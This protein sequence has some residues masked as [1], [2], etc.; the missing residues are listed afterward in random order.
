MSTEVLR[1]EGHEVMNSFTLDANGSGILEEITMEETVAGSRTL[2]AA[3][4]KGDD[5]DFSY[6]YTISVETSDPSGVKESHSDS[7]KVLINVAVFFLLSPKLPGNQ[8]PVCK[9]QKSSFTPSNILDFF[10]FL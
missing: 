7:K 10:G 3:V 8:C 9:K 6:E 2:K 4:I 5:I 1:A